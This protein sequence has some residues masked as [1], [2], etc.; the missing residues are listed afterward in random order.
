MLRKIRII[1]AAVFLTGI[2]LL[3]LGVGA[4]WWGWMASLQFLPACL[5][6]N[7]AVIAAVLLVTFVFGRI[8]CSVICPLGVFQDIVIALRRRLDKIFARRMALRHSAYHA[9]KFSFA[10]ERKWL[11]YG[12]L[13]LT[14]FAILTGFQGAVALIAPYSAYGRMIRSIIGIGSGAPALLLAVGLGSYLLII[15]LSV[16]WGRAWCNNICPVGTVLGTV[17]RHSVFKIHIDES[18]CVGCLSCGKKCKASCIDME[19]HTID[20]SR[21]VDCFDCIENCREGAIS[22]SVAPRN[23]GGS[24]SLSRPDSLSRRGFLSAAAVLTGTTLAADEL[25]LDGGLAEVIDKQDPHRKGFLVPPGASSAEDF[26]SRCTACQLC[27]ASCPSHVLRP[28]TDPGHLLQPRMGYEKGFCRPECTVCSDICPSG[29]IR[30]IEKDRKTLIHIGHASVDEA[31]CISCGKCVR[32]CPV[33][34]VV[35]YDNAEGKRV[36][37]VARHQCIGC[38]KCEY[39]CP[40][41]PLSAIVVDAIESHYE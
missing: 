13:A 25:K 7:V 2:T 29:A 40:V 41:R 24:G 11:R 4:R 3:F 5:S 21:C 12:V 35:M 16:L 26:Y 1:L 34:A 14:V 22:F 8:Y 32:V 6:L 9:R 28:S 33:G 18:K 27:V 37:T 15:V 31:S 19:H 30:P 39:L 10:K 36:A 23:S 38:G 20:T 17:S